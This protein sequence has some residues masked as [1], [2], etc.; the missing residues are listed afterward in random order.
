MAGI[1]PT[2][3]AKARDAGYSDQEIVAHLAD[4]SP[5]QFKQALDAGYSPKEILDHLSGSKAEPSGVAAGFK[6]GLAS[7]LGGDAKTA[8]Y[9]AGA[10]APDVSG[11]I[12]P[13]NYV[14]A[15]VTGGSL[16]P[17]KWNYGQIPQAI[18]EASPGLAQDVA[19][20]STAGAMAKKLLPARYAALVAGGAGAVSAATR[21]LGNKAKEDAVART[22]DQNAEPELQDKGRA[23]AT[24]APEAALS[25]LPVT[26]FLPGANKVTSVGVNGVSDAVKK[27]LTT[28]AVGGGSAAGADVIDQ[29]G[30][31]L[32]T[33][34]GLAVDPT[35]TLNSAVTGAA[36]SGALAAPRFAADAGKAVSLREFGG[37][38]QA[39]SEAVANRMLQAAPEGLGKTIGGAKV[40][41]RALANVKTDIG[42]E[43]GDSARDV[44]S[45]T[46]LSTEADNALQRAQAGKPLTADDVDLIDKEAPGTNAAFLARQARMTQLLQD[47]GTFQNERWAGGLSGKLDKAVGYWLPKA[48]FISA[49]GEAT[50]HD[51]IGAYAPHVIGGAAAGYLGA[52]A[53]DSLT[54]MRSPAKTFTD[55]FANQNQQVRVPQPAAPAAP[56]PPSVPNVPPPAPSPWGYVQ[57]PAPQANANALN[58]GVQ[59]ALRMYA[60]KQKYVTQTQAQAQAQARKQQSLQQQ[61]QSILQQAQPQP[62]P[63][64]PEATQIDPLSLPSD[65]TKRSKTL[66]SALAK[67]QKMK[68]AAES[69]GKITKA[70]GKVQSEN[71]DPYAAEDN[72][73]Y[74][75]IPHDEQ[76]KNGLHI[77]DIVREE[78]RRHGVRDARKEEY[79]NSVRDTTSERMHR[80]ETVAQDAPSQDAPHLADLLR[81]M[82]HINSA[83]IGAR[84]IM[85][86]KG[87]LTPE[88]YQAVKSSFN[89][90]V[91]HRVFHK[92]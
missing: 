78:L 10:D 26:R 68:G 56:T 8:K 53:V 17:L 37:D 69:P 42:N 12:A 4:K 80:I 27:Y 66:M 83:K 70:N 32:G 33:D 60:A 85:S 36:T 50:G 2:A 25:A 91:L 31:T 43:L 44:R 79:G 92:P 45:N 55:T 41:A 34:K 89:N 1:D 49:A 77:E 3:V 16:D 90:D 13:S 82:L 61:A 76:Y 24:V 29:V 72:N 87:L 74:E 7:T 38:N 30:S 15:D 81:Q 46:T 58:T 35:R 73:F 22:G 18:A 88:T 57:P 9:F 40:D 52:R 84:A 54:G 5:D 67:V 65:I 20:A 47:N 86:Y 21:M 11:A 71:V 64:A 39:A 19:V 28:A 48:A 51:F 63:A 23:L 75:Q 59:A 62:A 6:S 14:P